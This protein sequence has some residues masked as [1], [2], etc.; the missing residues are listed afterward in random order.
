MRIRAIKPEFWR[1]EDINDMSIEDR[2]LFIGLWSY[3]DDNGVGVDRESNVTADLFAHDLSVS[4]HDTLM[5]VQAGLNRLH[6]QGVIERYRVEKK[7]FLHIANWDKHQKINRPS[8]GRYP[9]PSGENLI[10]PGQFSEPS[11]N[12]HEPSRPGTG[13]QG[14]RGTGEQGISTS[15]V[16][17][18]P[19]PA[20]AV[21][22]TVHAR[23][24]EFWDAYSKK[25]GKGAAEK[26]FAK[27]AKKADP[28]EI[29]RAAHVHAD[30]HQIKRTEFKFI[31]YPATWLNESRW[32]DDL[33]QDEQGPT[34]RLDGFRDVHEELVRRQQ[35]KQSDVR[36][37]GG[38][39]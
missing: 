24:N 5:R 38:S 3:V 11:L 7:R 35:S 2:L 10:E 20:N 9:L 6:T 33:D 19:T 23:F 36:Q 34:T 8:P 15:L 22:V 27:A 13:E 16:P 14:N 30:Y 32:G 26:A 39:R 31:P 12:P 29:I 18:D 21:A 1:S 4:P 17:R 25:R 37:I 28:S